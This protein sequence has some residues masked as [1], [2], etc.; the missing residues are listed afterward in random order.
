M[1]D[2]ILERK[3]S[4][5][6]GNSFE[7]KHDNYAE[8]IH[9]EYEEHMS[10]FKTSKLQD[11]LSTEQK[12]TTIYPS[13]S[14]QSESETD[15]IYDE[16]YSCFMCNIS[17]DTQFELDEHL[18]SHNDDET[19]HHS[20]INSISE[21]LPQESI[22]PSKYLRCNECFKLCKSQLSYN[23]HMLTHT[24]EKPHHCR[25]CDRKF[26]HIANFRTH[27]KS[28]NNVRHL[29]CSL[30]CK[31]IVGEKNYYI[32]YM[33]VHNKM[34]VRQPRPYQSSSSDSD[35]DFNPKISYYK[36]KK[37]NV[38]NGKT[39][40]D[41][42]PFGPLFAKKAW[43]K[44][45]R[46]FEHDDS[47]IE[48]QKTERDAVQEAIENSRIDIQNML[49]KRKQH[50]IDYNTEEYQKLIESLVDEKNSTGQINEAKLIGPLFWKNALIKAGLVEEYILP[51]Q[52]QS[53]LRVT[54]CVSCRKCFA[55]LP[56]CNDS[57]ITP[58]TPPCSSCFMMKNE[59]TLNKHKS[60]QHKEN[61]PFF[62]K[63]CLSESNTWY[64]YVQHMKMHLKYAAR[65]SECIYN[66]INKPEQ[67]IFLCHE[68]DMSFD[69]DEQLKDHVNSHLEHG[70]CNGYNLN[71]VA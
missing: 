41:S 7:L 31:T 11:E 15:E 5:T 1:D 24:G 62:C 54:E 40:K 20:N 25:V 19:F 26:R 66:M 21:P 14:I 43:E 6:N 59:T 44:K 17:Y 52:F 16:C 46:Q 35:E 13:E 45:Q 47:D 8:E 39:P 61:P 10:G 65:C 32:H 34:A 71:S 37:V 70:Q 18:R 38:R 68:C 22:R 2:M 51:V 27:L 30:C 67:V 36:K 64:D 55:R 53:Q 50:L 23:E 48:K 56:K 58:S 63:E 57:N 9:N 4:Y 42:E 28:H 29:V 12:I 60:E 69:S 33:D 49:R 3:E